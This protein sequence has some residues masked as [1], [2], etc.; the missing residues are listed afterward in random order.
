MDGDA[1]NL[2]LGVY[3]TGTG[4]CRGSAPEPPPSPQ[5]LFERGAI[6]NKLTQVGRKQPEESKVQYVPGITL[7]RFLSADV[8]VS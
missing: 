6:R 3:G 2:R 4:L 5:P 1:V 7:Y 8:R